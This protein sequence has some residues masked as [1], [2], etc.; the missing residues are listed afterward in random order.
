MTG[1]T[2]QSAGEIINGLEIT[3]P[4]INA[5]FNRLADSFNAVTGHAHDGSIGNGP[6][7]NLSTSVTGVLQAV[8]GGS[9]GRNNVFA[10]APAA[11]NDNTQGYAPGS[12]WIN[13][14]NGRLYFCVGNATNAAV[15]RELVQIQTGNTILPLTNNTVDLG[16]TSIRFKDAFFAGTVTTDKVTGL[17]APTNSTDAATKA[18]VDVIAGATDTAVAAAA[19]ATSTLQTFQN[20]Y[21]GPRTTAPTDNVAEGD[22]YFDTVGKVMLVY[23]GTAWNPVVEASLGGIRRSQFIVDTAGQTTFSAGGSYTFAQVYL[24]GLKLAVGVDYTEASPNIVLTA[25]ASIDDVVEVFAYEANDA[26]DY[27]TKSASDSR[28][29]QLSGAQTIS[30]IKTFTS[31]LVG[32]GESLTSLNANNLSTGTVADARIPAGIV[33]A[34]RALIAGDGILPLGDLTTDRTVAVDSTVARLTATQTLTNKTLT[35]PVING[36]TISGIT[37]LEIA[38]GGTGASDAA[39]ARTNLGAQATITGAATTIT[40]ANLTANR[41]VVSDGSG[42]VI[43]SSAS[44]TEVGY[45]VGTT[46]S[47]QTQINNRQ[48]LADNLTAVSGVTDAGIIARTGTGTAAARTI[49]AGTGVTITNGNGVSGDPVVSLNISSQAQAEGF[50]DNTT[51]ISPLRLGQV[52]AKGLYEDVV[53]NPASAGSVVFTD[54]LPGV[55][56]FIIFRVFNTSSDGRALRISLSVNNGTNWT[57]AQTGTSA[58]FNTFSCS[59][60]A[61]V[62]TTYGVGFFTASRDN[63]SSVKSG[64]DITSMGLTMPINAIRIDWN[65]DNFGAQA[66]QAVIIRRIK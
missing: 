40:S 27:Y 65:G 55:Y 48:P 36:G 53:V 22:I 28:F 33:R 17:S 66:N 25:G 29:V 26:T 50:T 51:A 42:K 11:S 18:Y 16:T 32:S 35:S 13:S 45:L 61:E 2:R 15:W 38:D 41:A 46:S 58:A 37:D 5:E 34:T 47:I 63:S 59:G 62:D 39:T 6:Q 49:T 20:Q 12:V 3:A 54:L 23:D 30:G 21:Y 14:V 19:S 60:S 1:Y 64:G 7:I 4:P 9:G 31:P 8:N 24:N 44:A 57:V 43:A 52:L 56:Q 10:G